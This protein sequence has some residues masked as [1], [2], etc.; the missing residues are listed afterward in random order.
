MRLLNL[1]SGRS[2]KCPTE[3]QPAALEINSEMST[4]RHMWAK[5]LVGY[6]GNK[7]HDAFNTEV[8]Q[9]LRLHALKMQSTGQH[10]GHISW[11]DLLHGLAACQAG[12]ASGPDGHSPDTFRSLP[13]ALRMSLLRA[14]HHALTHPFDTSVPDAWRQLTLFWF[15]KT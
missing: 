9:E 14:L 4:D 10:V 2:S 12:K 6:L 8:Q 11:F 5:D 7:Y 1:F 15:S 13:V 3:T